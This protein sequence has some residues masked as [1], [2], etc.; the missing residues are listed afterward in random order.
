MVA[1]QVI[2]KRYITE[3]NS[4]IFI[5]ASRAAVFSYVTV[6]D[7]RDCPGYKIT[8]VIDVMAAKEL[9]VVSP[10]RNDTGPYREKL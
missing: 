3:G 4:E 6:K 7:R 8:N 5:K 9:N 1:K 10:W 2:K